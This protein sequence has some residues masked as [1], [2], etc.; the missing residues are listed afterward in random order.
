M[1]DKR[2]AQE[3]H[4]RPSCG[5]LPF[6]RRIATVREQKLARPQRNGFESFTAPRAVVLVCK[7]NPVSVVRRLGQSD[8]RVTTTLGDEAAHPH[9]S[10]DILA[11]KD[12]FLAECAEVDLARA[13][14]LEIVGNVDCPVSRLLSVGIGDARPLVEH[15]PAFPRCAVVARKIGGEL[16][17]PDV[18]VNRSVLH[19]NQ[20]PGLQATDEEAAGGMLDA[21]HVFERR[22]CRALVVGDRLADSGPRAR[23]A[24]NVAVLLFNEVM[25]V[26]APVDLRH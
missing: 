22:P 9:L 3:L 12:V 19:Q 1:P 8:R 25:L 13:G 10:G 20:V 21:L 24:Q 15:E 5:Q 23:P 7:R 14:P 11:R 26:E 4:V 16:L 17:A 18:L 6:R 2:D